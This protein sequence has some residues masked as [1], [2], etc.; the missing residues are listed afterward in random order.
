M[1]R[2]GGFAVAQQILSASLSRVLLLV[3]QSGRL[4][5]EN[6][7]KDRNQ[8][9]S[10][11]QWRHYVNRFGSVCGTGTDHGTLP[12]AELW[13]QALL[14]AIGELDNRTSLTLRL[15]QDSAREWFALESD[16]VRS[17]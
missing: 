3:Q 11:E 14:Q 16:A 1:L 15:A 17:R 12:E 2:M 4:D 6:L 8:V 13:T 5:R 7:K 10:E 9:W